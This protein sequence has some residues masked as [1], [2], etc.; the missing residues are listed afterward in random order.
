MAKPGRAG[1]LGPVFRFECV[2]A[3][4]RWQLYAGRILLVGCLLGA[5]G[6][7]WLPEGYVVQSYEDYARLGQSFLLV[8]SLVQLV[9]VML[10]AP[11]ATAGA[12]CV[13]K[14]RGTLVHAF[15][16]D[17]A[18]REIVIGKLGARLLTV[19]SL[20][21]CSLP[22]LAIVGL[23]GGIDPGAA[24]GAALVTMGVALVTCAVAL[25]CSVWAHKM[26]HALLAT[27]VVLLMWM[28]AYPL[29]I[30]AGWAPAAPVVSWPVA[31][32]LTNPISAAIVPILDPTPF[33]LPEQLAFLVGSI[34]ISSLLAGLAILKLRP[35]T[36]GQVSRPARRARPGVPAKI[37]ALLPEP[38]L[39]GNPILWRE[40]HRKRP[41][42][43]IGRFW[44]AYAVVSTLASLAA[45]AGYYIEPGFPDVLALASWVIAAQV[46]FGLF[47][48]SIAAATALAEERDRGSL[49]VLL[50]TPLST[51]TILWGKWWGTFALAPRL[52]ILPTWVAAAMAL[53]TGNW[54]AVLTMVATIL[55]LSAATTS[56]GLAVATWVPRL[57]RAVIVS[58]LALAFWTFGWPYL[59]E[60]LWFGGRTPAAIWSLGSPF[61]GVRS[62]A[63]WAGQLSL[64]YW[65]NWGFLSFLPWNGTSW[66]QP[67][68]QPIWFLVWLALDVA[69]ALALLCATTWTF[70]RCLGRVVERRSAPPAWHSWPSL[71][72]ARKILLTKLY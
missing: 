60:A 59:M 38:P 30:L 26:H 34:G 16:T 69:A 63:I 72:R 66:A 50:A 14:A 20:A 24:L 70:D 67:D 35:V 27:N 43:W 42:R 53:V 13:D 39:D 21:A 41:S 62:T 6:L 37:M 28:L 3:A 61:L 25:L 51:R 65:G 55:A 2:A 71:A 57:G 22:V 5:L 45:I 12:I 49:D 58:L 33:G 32:A 44:T 18:D 17:L 48:L 40:W 19:L 1:W 56:M 11:A 68:P 7:A 64:W 29:L 4:R 36:L 10:A 31:A 46:S 15:V 54:L 9:A 23:Q 8:V 52:L 47:L